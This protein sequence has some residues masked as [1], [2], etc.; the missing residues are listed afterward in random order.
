MSSG[1]VMLAEWIVRDVSKV[2][3]NNPQRSRPGGRPQNKWW[4]CVQIDINKCKITNWKERSKNVD[5]W[6]KSVKEAKVHIGLYCQKR[7][8]R[9]R[10]RR[11]CNCS[12]VAT[13][14]VIFVNYVTWT[15]GQYLYK[16]TVP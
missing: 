7:R 16:C 5:D 14:L 11:E 13:M 2:F 1:L 12:C 4:H 15:S 9:R 10:R 6:Q 3:S 8:R